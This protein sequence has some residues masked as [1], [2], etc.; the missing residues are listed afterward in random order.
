[1]KLRWFLVNY[2][3]TV[4]YFSYKCFICAS[5]CLCVKRSDKNCIFRI[6]LLYNGPLFLL[7]IYISFLSWSS[8]FSKVRK[9]KVEFWNLSH[10]NIVASIACNWILGLSM[11]TAIVPISVTLHKLLCITID[12]RLCPLAM[13]QRIVHRCTCVQQTTNCSSV[14]NVGQRSVRGGRLLWS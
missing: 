11:Y 13:W 14:P 1:M 12:R 4:L 6:T 3:P 9:Y 2:S 5:R 10:K 7:H 8:Y